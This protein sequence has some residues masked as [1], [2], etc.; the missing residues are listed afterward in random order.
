MATIA[1][2][3]VIAAGFS[4]AVGD[5]RTLSASPV[6]ANPAGGAI[7][8]GAIAAICPTFQAGATGKAEAGPI[9]QADVTLRAFSTTAAAIVSA[10]RFSLALRCA[11]AVLTDICACIRLSVR[12]CLCP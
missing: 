1:L 7:T 10:T 11:A 2:A 5:T 4:C 3:T 6:V 8:A 9:V 12:G